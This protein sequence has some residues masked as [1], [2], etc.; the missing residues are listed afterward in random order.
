MDVYRPYLGDEY[1]RMKSTYER[2]IWV[3]DE[4]YKLKLEWLKLNAEVTPME[5]FEVWNKEDYDTKR[6]R[7]REN[8]ARR[9]QDD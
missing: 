3:L 1:E 5:V 9:L 8:Q 7:T 6:T 2:A 4:T